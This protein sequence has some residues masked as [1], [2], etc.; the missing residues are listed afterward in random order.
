MHLRS[1]NKK[2]KGVSLHDS[3]GTDTDGNEIKVI[4]ILGTESDASRIKY[5]SRSRRVRFIE[6]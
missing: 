3:I 4:D 6:F 1:L 5:S 2:L